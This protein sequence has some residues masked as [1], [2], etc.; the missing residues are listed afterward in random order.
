MNDKGDGTPDSMQAGKMPAA[1]EKA[2]N[3][4]IYRDWWSVRGSQASSAPSNTSIRIQVKSNGDLHLPQQLKQRLGLSAG[5]ELIVKETPEGLL[6]WPADPPL[7]KIYIEPTTACNFHCRTC[8]RN[9]WDE[10]LGSMAFSTFRKLLADLK[11]VKTLR[12]IAFW[13]IGEPLLHPRIVEMIALAHALGVRT[14][15]I[16]NGALLNTSMAQGL[17]NAGLDTLVVSV[18]G[19]SSDAYEEIRCGGNFEQVQENITELHRIQWEM[20]RQ[21]PELGLEFV[22]M[23]RNMDQLPKLWE[24]A[25]SLGAA[26][27]IISNL[28]PYTEDMKDEILYKQSARMDND[29]YRSRWSPEVMLPRI[30]MQSEYMDPLIKLLYLTGRPKIGLKEHTA[31]DEGHCP[32]IWQGST[33]VSWTGDVSPCVALMHSYPCFVL[34]RKKDIK[35]AIFGNVMEEKLIDIWNNDVYQTFRQRVRNFDFPPCIDC[36]GCDFAESNQEDCFG[37][38]HPVCGDCLWARRVIL[39]P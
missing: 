26:F 27:I 35:R 15:L 30:D 28:L 37:N 33:A 4:Y 14:E 1:M 32:F 6:V 21:N 20:G 16:T 18:D 7:A 29:L 36:G 19:A 24:T 38:P 39:C 10:Q 13:G 2:V 17:I 3:R 11:K 5:S 22:V 25:F 31:S 8:V 23:Q 12:E 9:A 34:D